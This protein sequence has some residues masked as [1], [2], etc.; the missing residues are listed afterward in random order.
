MKSLWKKIVNFYTG[1]TMDLED[2][3][4]WLKEMEKHRKRNQSLL[5]LERL[6]KDIE[7]ADEDGKIEGEED[8]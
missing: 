1:K 3:E 8:E 4:N 6:F 7:E 2:Q 5:G